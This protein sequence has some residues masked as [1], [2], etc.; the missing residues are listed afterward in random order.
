V[1]GSAGARN[2]GARGGGELDAGAELAGGGLD[3]AEGDADVPCFVQPAATSASA[4]TIRT[5]LERAAPG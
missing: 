1:T 2:T 4:A 3:G 5:R